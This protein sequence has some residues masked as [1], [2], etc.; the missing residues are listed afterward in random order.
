MAFRAARADGS[1]R[2][3]SSLGAVARRNLALLLIAGIALI[4]SGCSDRA[5]MF[6]PRSRSNSELAVPSLRANKVSS[7]SIPDQYIVVFKS[8]VA[9]A[10]GLAKEIITQANGTHLF[11]YTAAL[12]GF[13]ARMSAQA[14]EA[15]SHNPN[16]ESVEQDQEVEVADVQTYTPSWGIDRIDQPLL[17]MNGQYSYSVTGSGVNAYMIDTGI[18]GTH[19][20]F[21]GRALSGFTSVAD[22]NGT[23]DCHWHGTHVAGI[24]GGATVGVAKAVT[25][26]AV[27]VL[28]CNGS[29]STSGVIAG[30]DWVTANRRLPAVANMSLS[31]DY[32]DALNTAIQNS[33]NAGVTYV[34]AAGNSAANACAYSPSSIASAIVV[35]ATTAGDEQASYSNFG[36]CVD[37]YAPGTGITSAWSAYDEGLI[38][39][40]GTSMASPHV[41][42]AA[43]LYLQLHPAAT[44]AE[45]TQSILGAATG[46]VLTLLGAGSPNRLL[47]VNGPAVGLIVPAPPVAPAPPPVNNPPV[48]VFSVSCPSQKN[49]CAFDASLSR[50]DSR[51]ATY[52]WNFGDGATTLNAASPSTTHSYQRKG[53]YMTTLTVTDDGGLSAS[54]AKSI[55]VKSVSNR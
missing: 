46:N 8:H 54:A 22:G 6:A 1:R 30:V 19:T 45:V 11:T 13:A 5:N 53:T 25:L 32:S 23:D 15:L 43:V 2:R 18:K 28:D 37:L 52:S 51:I 36:S 4:A 14:A 33:I 44:P 12:H 42:G 49:N 27:R 31:G 55:T 3:H 41:A 10:P 29:G 26:Y 9:D 34:V 20:Q 17:P 39:A 47:R 40:S 7:S 48:A 50:D 38:K 21:G 24:V 35:G 16:V